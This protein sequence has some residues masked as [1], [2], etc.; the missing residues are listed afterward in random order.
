MKMKTK[1]EN[2]QTEHEEEKMLIWVFN[3]NGVLFR[4][5]EECEY[6]NLLTE[7]YISKTSLYQYLKS[8]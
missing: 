3:S 7:N 1:K 2:S 4:N 6:R 8:F 5:H